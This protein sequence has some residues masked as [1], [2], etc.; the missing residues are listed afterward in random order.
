MNEDTKYSIRLA[1][2]TGGLETIKTMR[3]FLDELE[4]EMTKLEA[5]CEAEW[6]ASLKE[7]GDE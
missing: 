3:I 1:S 2:L 4:K 7:N 6:N 5:K